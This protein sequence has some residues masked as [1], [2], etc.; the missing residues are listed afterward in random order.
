MRDRWFIWDKKR[1]RPLWEPDYQYPLWRVF[2]SQRSAENYLKKTT[3][4][5]YKVRCV[6]AKL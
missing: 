4:D 1:A 5:S 6:E 3:V 2:P